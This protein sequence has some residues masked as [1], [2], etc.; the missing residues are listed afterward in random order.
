MPAELG[1]DLYVLLKDRSDIEPLQAE[2]ERFVEKRLQL[3]GRPS[4]SSPEIRRSA[5]IS[6]SLEESYWIFLIR[7]GNARQQGLDFFVI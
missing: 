2:I 6:M 3:V 1:A 7:S 5:Q 4:L